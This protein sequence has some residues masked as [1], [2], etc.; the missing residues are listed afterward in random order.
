MTGINPGFTVIEWDAEFMVPVNTHT[1]YMDMVE[2]NKNPTQEPKWTLLHDALNEYGLKDLS[3]DS[4][5]GLLN[6]MYND[7]NLATKY[8]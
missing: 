4:M 5:S 3:P 2:S 7:K 8:E 1:Y 6:R